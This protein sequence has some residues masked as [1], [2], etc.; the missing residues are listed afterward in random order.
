MVQ[1][2]SNMWHETAASMLQS[3]L[4]K[5]PFHKVF[6]ILGTPKSQQTMPQ[7]IPCIAGIHFCLS[8]THS[9]LCL[10]DAKQDAICVQTD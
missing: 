1:K 10:R 8:S 6:G 7:G 4:A 3:I 9:W 5:N 2:A